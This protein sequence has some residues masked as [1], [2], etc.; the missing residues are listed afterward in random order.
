MYGTPWHGDYTGVSPEGVP[1]EKVFL[2]RHGDDNQARRVVGAEAASM[3]LARCFPPFWDAAG[4]GFTVDFIAQLAE[5]VPCY[6]LG[7][8]PDERAVEYVRCVA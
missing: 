4:M 6:E 5:V 7:F 2:L 3:L 1:L 8:V